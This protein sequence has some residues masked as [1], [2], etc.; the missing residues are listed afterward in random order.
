MQPW[1]AKAFYGV[2]GA[3]FSYDVGS[4]VYRKHNEGHGPD[5]LA[6]TAAHGVTFHLGVSFA[7]PAVV[8]KNAVQGAHIILSA[9][10]FASLPRL[11]RFGPPAVGLACIPFLPLIDGPASK[12]LDSCF[13]LIAPQWRKGES[14]HKHHH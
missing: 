6:A 12:V 14:G 10:M 4:D 2:A 11:A 13:D 9:P 3:Y 8:I 7:L 5:V 1:V